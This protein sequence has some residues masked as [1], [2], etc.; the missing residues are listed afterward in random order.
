MRP[1]SSSA[2]RV[3]LKRS[4]LPWLCGWNG[5]LCQGAT[6]CSINHAPSLV[7]ERSPVSP[8]GLA[9]AAQDLGD[10]RGRRRRQSLPTQAGRDLAATPCR[11]RLTYRQNRCFHL[12]ARPRRRSMWPARTMGQACRATSS[13]SLQPLVQNPWLHLEPP[14][15]LAPVRPLC[16]RKPAKL[17][18]R[19]FLVLERHRKPHGS[20]PPECSPCLR[21]PV[22]YLPGSYSCGQGGS[23]SKAKRWSRGRG[24]PGS[25]PR[26]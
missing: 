12:G 8:H 18:A 5:A 6:P 22:H 24:R 17:L 19:S 21:T 7:S 9:I 13:I 14:A 2:L 1:S 20:T 4:F 10:G 15:Q 3:R 16:R 26:R 11:V 25:R 23:A